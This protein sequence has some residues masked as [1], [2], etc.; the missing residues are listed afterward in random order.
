MIDSEISESDNIA[1]TAVAKRELHQA[2][3]VQSSVIAFGAQENGGLKLTSLPT[4]TQPKSAQALVDAKLAAG[5]VLSFN[6]VDSS[7]GMWDAGLRTHDTGL[8]HEQ[9][10]RPEASGAAVAS[11][12]IHQL[13]GVPQL[14]AKSQAVRRHAHH[15]KTKKKRVM[16]TVARQIR[17]HVDNLS[18]AVPGLAYDLSHIQD[19]RTTQDS[20]YSTIEFVF[21][22]GGRG[23]YLAIILSLAAVIAAAARCIE[24]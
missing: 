20:R 13:V 3:T 1:S 14:Q 6:T 23:L 17:M 11:A 4:P 10:I 16:T 19:I 8:P 18:T 21:G 5:R 9:S 7:A 2:G 12:S 22:R 24:R 15:P